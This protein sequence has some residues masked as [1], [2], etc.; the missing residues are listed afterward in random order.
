MGTLSEVLQL[1]N[2]MQ[3]LF[4]RALPSALV[5]PPNLES[6]D[7]YPE[8]GLKALTKSSLHKTAVLKGPR[9]RP[10]IEISLSVKYPKYAKYVSVCI[11]M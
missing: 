8:S 10:C 7:L 2:K 5:I 3:A 6:Q 4:A 9:K 1:V 11:Y